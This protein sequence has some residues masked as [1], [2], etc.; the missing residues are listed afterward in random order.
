MPPLPSNDPTPGIGHNQLAGDFLLSCIE[1]VERI[2]QEIATLNLGKSDVYRE[3][4]GK[5]FDVATVRR[6]L[7]ELKVDPAKREE[8][9]AVFDLYFTAVKAARDDA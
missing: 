1:R 3:M 6:V 8:R 9:E 2:E 5:G 7:K 4:R